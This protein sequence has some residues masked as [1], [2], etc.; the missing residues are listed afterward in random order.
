MTMDP[1][2]SALSSTANGGQ[3]QG[4]RWRLALW[5][6]AV[7]L[8]LLP[9]LAGADWSAGD[10]IFA[11]VLLFGS[12]GAY[13]LMTRQTGGAAYRAGAGLGIL[14]TLL[15]VWS[16]A[17]VGL[18]D[19]AADVM[20]LGIPL[21]LAIGTLVTRLQPAGMARTMLAAALVLVLIVVFALLAGTVPAHNSA[22]EVLGVAGG[23]ASLFAGS[24]LFFQRAARSGQD[25][26]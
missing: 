17:A 6:A 10:F 1:Q 19:G 7:F 3:P 2:G 21:V 18:T 15:F 22:L 14:T 9:F 24:A 26:T 4:G 16:N 12:L 23:F 8:L 11:G 20:L 5:P 25:A 13:E